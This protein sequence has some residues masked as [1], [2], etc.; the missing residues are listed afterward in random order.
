MLATLTSSTTSVFNHNKSKRFW[1]SCFIFVLLLPLGYSYFSIVQWFSEDAVRNDYGIF[2]LSNH[3][4]QDSAKNPYTTIYAYA[5][6]EF[7]T[8]ANLKLKEIPK[9]LNPPFFIAATA[10]LTKLDYK[11]SFYCWTI[12]SV[13]AGI[14]SIVLLVRCYFVKGRRLLIGLGLILAFFSY[15]PTVINIQDGQLSLILLLLLTLSFISL[16]FNIDYSAGLLLGIAISI[17]PILGLFAILL[18][19]QRRWYGLICLSITYLICCLVAYLLLGSPGYEAYAWCLQHVGWYS[20]GANVSLLGF[21]TRLLGNQE[22]NFPLI[23]AS[24]ITKPLYYVLSTMII[25]IWVYYNHQKQQTNWQ[26]DWGFASTIIVTLL[27]SPLG[28]L[29]YFTWLIIAALV[30]WEG[31]CH[32]LRYNHLILLLWAISISLSTIAFPALPRE[33]IHGATVILGWYGIGFYG[34]I[35]ALAGLIILRHQL[36]I[37]PLIEPIKM[38]SLIK[39]M[40]FYSVIL[41]FS[42]SNIL[43]LGNEFKQSYQT[44]NPTE[45]HSLYFTK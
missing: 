12:L 1:L 41:L 17:K 43:Y 34:L 37:T 36:Q 30:V 8:Q 28:W 19:L 40:L 26:R 13:A 45:F 3:F 33:Y 44:L 32:S 4:F 22:A 29:Y 38:T 27:I 35:C 14:I 15:F 7:S 2:Y 11:H 39:Q 16:K 6:D 42:Y 31:I 10:G 9:N 21:L 23:S 20:N 18:F 5:I 24:I 25:S